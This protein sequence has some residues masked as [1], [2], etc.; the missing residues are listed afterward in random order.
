M[1]ADRAVRILVA[2]RVQ[3]VGFRWWLSRQAKRL[4]VRGWIRNLPDG[5]VEI[6][7]AGTEDDLRELE[8]LAADGPRSAHV[9][10]VDKAD[11][12][13]HTVDSKSF[14]IR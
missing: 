11:V 10:R 9:D 3:G 2:G 13:H 5:R 6:V 8:R 7:A 14:D 1:K 12:P 4:P